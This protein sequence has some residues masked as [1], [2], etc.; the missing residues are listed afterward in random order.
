MLET[1]FETADGAATLVDFM[2]RSSEHSSIVRFVIGTRGQVAMH[3]ELILRFGYGAVVPWVSRVETGA[4]R[5]IAGPDMVVLHTPV[6]VSGKDLT[7]VGEFTISRGE[8]IPFVLT[9]SPS[10]SPLPKPVDPTGALAETETYWREWTAKCRPAGRWSEAVRRSV[11]T[12]KALTYEPTG[13][14]VAAPTT[15][16]PERLGG[17]AQLGLP[18]LLAARRHADAAWRHACRILTRKRRPGASGCCARSP[19]ARISSRSCTASAASVV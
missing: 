18:L 16:L 1:H 15:S 17:T 13:G 11:I 8:T 12:L 6:H 10:H 4:L 7:T 14:I 5:A 19:A 3:T 2:P 9:Y